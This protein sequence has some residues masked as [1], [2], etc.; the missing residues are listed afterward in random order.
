MKVNVLCTRF[1]QCGRKTLSL[2][3]WNDAIRRTVND[4]NMILA[5]LDP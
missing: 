3:K 2:L 1:L 4:Q 5:W